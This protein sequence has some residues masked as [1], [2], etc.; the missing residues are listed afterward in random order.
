MGVVVRDNKEKEKKKMDGGGKKYKN[1]NENEKD[2]DYKKEL[3]IEL[4]KI[5]NSKIYSNKESLISDLFSHIL[6]KKNLYL[7]RKLGLLI[8]DKIE[9]SALHS[10]ML[11]GGGD[12]G[13]DDIKNNNNNEN[14]NENG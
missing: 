14:S 8:G 5:L 7:E 4:K 12:G 6:K 2:Y 10:Q 9:N 13:D 11:R 1:E 3:S